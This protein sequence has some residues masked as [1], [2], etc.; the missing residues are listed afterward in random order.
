MP[1]QNVFSPL[2]EEEELPLTLIDGQHEV[3]DPP[4]D[5]ELQMQMSEF[6]VPEPFKPAGRRS[7]KKD[8]MMSVPRK[9]WRSCD[10]CPSSDESKPDEAVAARVQAAPVTPILPMD[11]PSP[12]QALPCSMG[13]PKTNLII[14]CAQ[15]GIGTNP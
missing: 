13:P 11:L 4:P 14:L 8:K 9:A 15:L 10:C 5:V 6:P 3:E 7:R 1:V 2:Q 12:V